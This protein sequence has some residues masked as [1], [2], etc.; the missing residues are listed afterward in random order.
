MT[1]IELEP[2]EGRGGF[3]AGIHAALPHWLRPVLAVLHDATRGLFL[4]DGVMVACAVSYSLIFALFPFAIF[5]V[6]LGAVFGGSDLAAYISRE[7]LTVLPAH[8]IQSLSPELNRIFATGARPLTIGLVIT[9]ISITG[10]IEAIRDGLNRAYG[11]KEDRHLL[12]RYFSSVFFVFVGTAFLIVVAALGIAV[13][14]ALGIIDR[15]LPGLASQT[16]WLETARKAL[17]AVITLGMLFAFH[18][19]LPAR[20]TRIK[21]VAGGV[22]FTLIGWWVAGKIFG[23]YITEI[24]NYT[25]TYAGLAG[26]VILMF[27]LY[28]QALIFLYGAEL[29][30]SIADLRGDAVQ[31]ERVPLQ[32][33]R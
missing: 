11:C 19:L 7:A 27:F 22:F 33:T 25:A 1:D 13:P 6:A 31:K 18:V 4:H 30:R 5:V 16:G 3:L 23:L 14:I 10:S 26:I 28:I 12:R 20:R 9:L 8:V 29:N 32:A 21:G 2:E 15:Y 17:L 24:A